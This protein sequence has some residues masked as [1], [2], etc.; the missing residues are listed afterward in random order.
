MSGCSF[1]TGFARGCANSMAFGALTLANRYCYNSYSPFFSYNVNPYDTSYLA[2][3]FADL[4]SPTGLTSWVDGGYALN[5]QYYGGCTGISYGIGS[6]NYAYTPYNY[7]FSF[8][9]WC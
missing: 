5:R 7:G 3:C 6:W 8:G 4:D 9:C 2:T 1:W